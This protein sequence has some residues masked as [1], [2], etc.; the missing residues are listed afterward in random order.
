M[1]CIARAG[2]S[3]G[4]VER[5]EVVVVELDLGALGDVEAEAHEDVLHLAPRLG[6]QVQVA[7]RLRRVAGQRH[8][9]RG[10]RPRRRVEL[11]ASS[12]PV[13]ALRAAPRAPARTWLARL[14]DRPAL[15]GRQVADRRAGRRSARTCGRGSATRSSSSASVEL[16][17]AAIAASRLARAARRG[18]RWR[19]PSAAILV[20]AR[21][22][23]RS[24]P[25]RR[26]ASPGRRRAA[27]CARRAS[28]PASTSAGRPSRSAPRQRTTGPLGSTSGERPLGAAR[29]ARCACRPARRTPPAPAAGRTPSPCSPARPSASTGRRSP[30]PSTTG[31]SQ[32]ACAER[33]TVPTLPG[34]RDAVQVDRQ[35]AAGLGPA[36]RGRRRSRACPSRACSPRRAARA[37]RPSP[38]HE[39]HLGLPARRGG[40]LDQVLALGHEQVAAGRASAF[41]WSLRIVLSLF[42]VL[43]GDHWA[44]TERKRAPR[45][46]PR[47][48]ASVVADDQAAAASRARSAKRRNVSGSRTAM[49]AS[50][51]RSSSIPASFRPCM[52]WL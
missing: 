3:G 34:S 9:D 43:G 50:T 4:M 11:G 21:R 14:A 47:E 25:S 45:W 10:P 30:G 17:A 22:A 26:S 8:V 29:R 20:R 44:V 46:A 13:R 48:F 52:N 51:L 31:P 12:S 41:C 28:A 42:V 36:L 40:G 35:L 6:D 19:Q 49:S 27:G 16:R 37:R 33:M 2:W 24:P 38:G 15:L 5:G 18:G 23:R 39:Q 7:G 1:S 32:S